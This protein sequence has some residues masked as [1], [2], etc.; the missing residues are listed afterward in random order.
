MSNGL[1]PRTLT[2]SV[3]PIVSLLKSSSAKLKLLLKE[4]YLP[5]HEFFLALK[6]GLC[7]FV[8]LLY[9]LPDFLVYVFV[10]SFTVRFNL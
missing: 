9:N 2:I 6:K 5:L 1:G 4:L 3:R 10:G 8:A 7:S